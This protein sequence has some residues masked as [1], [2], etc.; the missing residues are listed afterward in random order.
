MFC[1]NLFPALEV[2]NHSYSNFHSFLS[3]ALGVD[4]TGIREAKLQLLAVKISTAPNH[5]CPLCCW[6]M[7]LSKHCRCLFGP[8]AKHFYP[9]L[10]LF[11]SASCN[12]FKKPQ[13]ESVKAVTFMATYLLLCK[14]TNG[15]SATLKSQRLH[16]S[17]WAQ[18][19]VMTANGFF[20][21]CDGSYLLLKKSY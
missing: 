15:I 2:W 9:A 7:A 5:L 17:I 18:P 10:I 11:L 3:S 4:R 16:W 1:L 6:V 13:A 12:V 21:L 19:K 20:G 8:W 14:W